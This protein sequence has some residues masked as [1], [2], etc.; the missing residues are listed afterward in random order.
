MELQRR[1]LHANVRLHAHR[2][3]ILLGA[4]V[5]AV[6]P[7]RAQSVEVSPL[8]VELAMNPGDTHTQAVTLTNQ[9]SEPIRI[10]ARTQDWFL[11]KDGTPQ[12]DAP[13]PD[14]EQ[15]FGS[16]AWL[17]LAPP[18]QIVQPGQQGIVRF[19]T[20]VPAGVAA[21]GYRGA[22]L[23]EFG[24]AAGDPA[25]QRRAVQFRSRIATLVYM[26]VGRTPIQVDLIDLASRR[27]PDQPPA[28]V[29]VLKNSGQGNVRTKGTV[30]VRD[31]GGGLVRTL[32]IPNVPLLPM[33]ER[34]VLVST[35]S[36]EEP[37]LTAGE[38]RIEVRL[39]VGM[40]EV[41]VGE[42]TLKVVR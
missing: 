39:D 2:A 17:R 20:A 30:Q 35:A 29:A 34:E 32:T 21:G 37:P 1:T 24:A 15:P 5:L 33:T 16:A 25:A 22:I 27:R 8:R 23:F 40:P 3:L 26:E 38:Y 28:I 12:F 36:G 41:I 6:L 10:R 31:A 18:E 7:A 13:L 19:T 11:T 9:G 4:V 42:T 14:A